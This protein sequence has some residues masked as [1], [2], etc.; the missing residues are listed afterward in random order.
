MNDMKRSLAMAARECYV[1]ELME[2]LGLEYDE[3]DEVVKEFENQEELADLL[4]QTTKDFYQKK[5]DDLQAS[6]KE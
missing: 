5:Y 2:D 6:R 1:A 3:A 4:F